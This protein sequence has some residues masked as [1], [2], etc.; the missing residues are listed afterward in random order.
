M[1]SHVVAPKVTHYTFSIEI[2]QAKVVQWF[3]LEEILYLLGAQFHGWWFN[4]LVTTY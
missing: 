2:S 4:R 3:C 1:E